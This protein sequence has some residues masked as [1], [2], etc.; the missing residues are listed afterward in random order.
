[1]KFD[2]LAKM[3]FESSTKEELEKILDGITIEDVTEDG[4]LATIVDEVRFELEMRG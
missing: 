3:N 4:R 1:M 2:E